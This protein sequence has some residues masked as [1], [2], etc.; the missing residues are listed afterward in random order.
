MADF[1]WISTI[2]AEKVDTPDT[3]FGGGSSG[4]LSG[5]VSAQSSI[6]GT[7]SVLMAL[8]GTIPAT[9]FLSGTIGG[10][11]SGLAGLVAAQSGLVGNLSRGLAYRGYSIEEIEDAIVAALEASARLNYV[12]TVERM[13]WDRINDLERFLARY[14]AIVVAYQGG[15]D[16]N[17]NYAVSDHR[18]EFSILCA[19]KNVRSPSAA[20]R[21]ITT[22]EKGVFDMLKDV[23]N[24]LNFSSLGLDIIACKTLGIRPIAATESMTV[25]SRDIEVTWRMVYGQ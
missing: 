1:E 13:P 4:G 22:A 17:D 5:A 14:P 21:G 20:A 6:S 7:L 25:F 12:K 24:A 9:S 2:D 10:V 16:N 15:T 3:E 11:H 23:T 8:S 18:G 19:H